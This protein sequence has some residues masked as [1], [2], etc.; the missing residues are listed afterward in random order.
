M[1]S[2]EG[3]DLNKEYGGLIKDLSRKYFHNNPRFSLEDLEAE[4]MAAV[5]KAVKERP[6]SEFKECTYVYK[7]IQLALMGFLRKNKF[8]VHV[9]EGEQKR[10]FKEG[11]YERLASES[12]AIR[13]DAVVFRE[14]E[15]GY[16]GGTDDR[17]DISGSWF[18]IAS[19]GEP[20][21]I[22][23]VI[24]TEMLEILN[25]EINALG[26]RDK[27][28]LNEFFIE[29]RQLNDIARDE[30]VSFQRIG[31]IKTRAFNKLKERMEKRY[32]GALA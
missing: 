19:S 13:A 24:K 28:V 20:P 29:G 31:Q 9:P 17:S 8:D 23:N 10:A 18:D 12:F 7:A 1:N 30:S 2:L 11:R 3:R 4:S 26:G 25:E 27:K 15:P 32:A 14:G 22:D 5:V 21:V 16:A 6:E